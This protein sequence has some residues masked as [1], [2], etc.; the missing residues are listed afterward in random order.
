MESSVYRAQPAATQ[1]LPSRN[2]RGD[3]KWPPISVRKR[4][5]AEEQAKADQDKG[6][7][8]RPRR[9]QRDYS[10]FFA[11]HAITNNYPGYRVPPG[12][13]YVTSIHQDQSEDDGRR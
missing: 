5:E 12:T 6:P 4:T 3:V 2:M 13:Q 7:L 10:N 9:I 8:H 11:Q 1:P